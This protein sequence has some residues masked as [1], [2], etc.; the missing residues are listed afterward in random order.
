MKRI[1]TISA[2]A[3]VVMLACGSNDTPVGI[4][5]PHYWDI[6]WSS[7]DTALT[8]IEMLAADQGWACGH[9]YSSAT[10]TYDALVLQYDGKTWNVNLFLPGD[11]GARLFA[12]DFVNAQD[13]WALGS[14]DWGNSGPVVLHYDG[15]SWTEVSNAGLFGGEMNLL[16]AVGETTYGSPTAS[17]HIITTALA[18][19]PTP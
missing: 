1:I 10:N 6:A 14:R 19:R 7:P 18:G 17:P 12:I 2:V 13:G 9:R 4:G 3:A 15:E 5:M 8:D 16:A 11:A